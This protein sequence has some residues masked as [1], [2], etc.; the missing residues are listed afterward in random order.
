MRICKSC[1]LGR[2][3]K[4]LCVCGD[5]QFD[6]INS[7]MNDY[8]QPVG[9]AL[10]EDTLTFK[11]PEKV[12]LTGKYCRLEPVNAEAHAES[13]FH[14]FSQNQS[15]QQ[16]TY[17]P[18][19]VPTVYSEFNDYVLGMENS[20]DYDCFTIINANN[21]AVGTFAL[22]RLDIVNGVVEVG[23]VT[24]SEKM[25]QTVVSTEAYYLLARYVFETLGFRRYEWKADALNEP[26]KKAAKRLGFSY[27][28]LFQQITTTHGRNRDT[29]WYAMTDIAW[30]NQVENYVK[31]LS[32][33]NFD[34]EGK[35]LSK[36]KFN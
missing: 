30:R 23:M 14:S 25:R 13:L 24:F 22:M 6:E 5:E 29:T 16:W 7:R 32:P 26:S 1:G 17:L 18:S 4:I 8:G 15:P 10:A 35:Q 34:N 20:N 33:E 28:G 36:L 12:V 2:I 9:V 3:D 11:K 21:E 31:W 19:A 27:E